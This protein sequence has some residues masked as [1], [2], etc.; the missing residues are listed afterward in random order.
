MTLLSLI[1]YV[2]AYHSIDKQLKKIKK[3]CN[4]GIRTDKGDHSV[5]SM[6]YCYIFYAR[7]SLVLICY[8]GC[9]TEVAAWRFATTTGYLHAGSIVA[10]IT[11]GASDLYV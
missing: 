11:I 9:S 3:K 2:G 4:L 10:G 6:V 8:L 7:Q 1:C 5:E